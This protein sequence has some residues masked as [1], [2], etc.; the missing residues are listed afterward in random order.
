METKPTT[1]PFAD[2]IPPDVLADTQAV[3]EKLMTGKP[4]DPETERRIRERGDQIR[5]RMTPSTDNFGVQVIREM[6][7]PLDE[8]Q[9]REL[10]LAQRDLLRRGERRLTDPDTGTTYVLVT[11]EEYRRLGGT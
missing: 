5:Q 2:V 8:D 11:E 3:I 6:R 1:V 4:L 10:T 7:G 9:E